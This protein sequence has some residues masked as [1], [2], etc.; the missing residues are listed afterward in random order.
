V[1]PEDVLDIAPDVL[2]H[3]LSLSYEALADGLDA[4]ALV[5]RLMQ[6]VAA[7]ERL[8]DKHVQVAA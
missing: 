4:D 8:L 7:P 2:R 5:L 1:R 3:R 6:R